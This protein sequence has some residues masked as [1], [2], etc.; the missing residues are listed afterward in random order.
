[1]TKNTKSASTKAPR[2]AKATGS[3]K[4]KTRK[5]TKAEAEAPTPLQLAKAQLDQGVSIAQSKGDTPAE[6]AL[7]SCIAAKSDRNLDEQGV[8]EYI[9][10]RLQKAEAA[11][12]EG[13]ASGDRRLLPAIAYKA[14]KA[15]LEQ[16]GGHM[17]FSE[18]E[19]SGSN[20]TPKINKDNGANT[21][22]ATKANDKAT[23]GK[24]Q[25]SLRQIMAIRAK[26]G[27]R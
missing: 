25:Y 4:A 24:R 5:A 15:A 23:S 9:S 26:T 2:T 10:F 27:H 20:L 18:A 21:N 16:L 12:E 3:T 19:L 7:Q 8:R 11:K 17:K 13:A 14:M 6:I 1:M 22:K